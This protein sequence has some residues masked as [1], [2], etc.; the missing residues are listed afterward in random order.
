M[1]HN[2]WS[3]NKNKNLLKW[4]NDLEYQWIINVFILYDLK[5]NESLLTWFIILISTI[6][7]SLIRR[8]VW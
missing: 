5:D 4:K 2:G 8:S 7:S 3:K 1:N 6:S